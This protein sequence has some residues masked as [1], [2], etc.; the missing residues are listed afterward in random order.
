MNLV[1]LIARKCTVSTNGLPC[2][3]TQ[4]PVSK[5]NDV[6]CASVGFCSLAQCHAGLQKRKH[7][8]HLFVY[9]L[10]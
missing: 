8:F 5:H 3:D 7:E 1:S 10:G 4:W 2:S 6:Q 9:C